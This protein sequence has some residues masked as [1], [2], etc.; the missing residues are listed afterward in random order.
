MSKLK[1]GHKSQ[2]H[3]IGETAIR[4]L[5]K[6]MGF[7]LKANKKAIERTA[8]ADRDGQFQQINWTGKAFEAEG[9]ETT[10]DYAIKKGNVKQCTASSHS[11]TTNIIN[12]LKTSGPG[13]RGS[14][15]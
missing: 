1:E 6:G 14:S 7:S 8:H 2:G 5:L 12:W 4:E 3:A 13:W 15:Q 9:L 11:W 10:I